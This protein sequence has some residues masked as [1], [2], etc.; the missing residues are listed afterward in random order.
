MDTV[1]R[2]AP[3]PE[4]LS[5]ADIRR[6]I[7]DAL[8]ALPKTSGK[9]LLVPP[10]HTRL[11]SMAGAIALAVKQE[12]PEDCRI[13]VL[14]ALGTHVAMTRDEW[15]A[16]Y[17]G[18]DYAKML[19]HHWRDE[20]VQIGVI[21]AEFVREV[22]GG[23][24][25]APIPVDVNRHL[26]DPSYDLILSIGQVVPHE[27]AG[28]ANHAKN[29]FVGCGGSGMINASHMLGA[30]CGMESA[31]GREKT[32]VRALFDYASER[33]TR[34]LPLY[35][36]LSVTTAD[37]DKLRLHGLFIGN[38]RDTFGDAARLSQEKNIFHLDKPLQKVIVMLDEA[39]FKSTWLGNKAIYRTRMA[40]ADGGE[41]FILAPGVCRFGEDAEADR[42]I[43]K[44]GYHGRDATLRQVAA[45]EELRK[46]LSAAAHLIHGSSDGRF[47]ITYCV[48]HLTREE[49]EGVGFRYLPYSQGAAE[50]SGLAPGTNTD[51]S[52]TEMYYIQNPAL[53]LWAV[54]GRIT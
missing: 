32:P 30:V 51:A 3:T 37:A 27:V 1:K 36:A 44:Y 39:E 23:L 8:K 42:L 41:L 43:R 15:D 9:V 45:Q 4:G 12:L 49:V 34:D 14:P 20:V 13:D 33:F 10:D 21:P 50:F 38:K 5:A 26:L 7:R 28:M 24:M 53:G 40:I 35:Y 11:H 25:D 22:S 48:R 47:S 46:N 16:M 54:K 6:A 31:M 17:P 2:Y 52:H 18:F 29:I 19:V